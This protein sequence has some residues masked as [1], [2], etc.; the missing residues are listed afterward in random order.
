MGGGVVIR[1]RTAAIRSESW[2]IFI[3]SV[4]LVI[5]L[6]IEASV[7][8]AAE[9]Q[10]IQARQEGDA[11][12][13]D[14]ALIGERGEKEAEVDVVFFLDGKEW[15]SSQLHVEGDYGKVK[16]GRGKSI[17]WNVPMD[18]PN[19]FKGEINWKVTAKS[20]SLA[21]VWKKSCG[22]FWGL[23]ITRVDGGL[24]NLYFCG[25][26]GCNLAKKNTTIYDDPDTNVIDKDTMHNKKTGT[27]FKRCSSTPPAGLR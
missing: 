4:F 10:D 17:L 9:V 15:K 27:T 22:D 20:D 7:L 14:Y 19:G 24:Y 18:F 26:N 6:V 5:W 13:L 11:I 21:G 12:I 23:A 8:F 25:N 1:M 3:A 2:V 16:V